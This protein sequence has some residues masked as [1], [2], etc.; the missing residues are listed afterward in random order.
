MT[1]PQPDPRETQAETP[2]TLEMPI[3]RM[4]LGYRGNKDG[5][6]YRDGWRQAA[7]AFM[8]YV[9]QAQRQRDEAIRKLEE[10]NPLETCQSCKVPMCPSQIEAGTCFKCIA[11]RFA[12]ERDEARQALS[13]RANEIAGSQAFVQLHQQT[14]TERDHWQS[15]AAQYSAER[16]SNANMAG[17]WQAKYKE[18]LNPLA[19]AV[20]RM[21]QL[22]VKQLEEVFN[23]APVE[24]PD[25]PIFIHARRRKAGIEAVRA[26][27]IQAA[28]GGES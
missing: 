19:E 10:A 22:T 25:S 7:G 1:A 16:E 20:R 6:H 21:E 13:D 24:N 11:D 8:P 2:E 27:L 17:M 9:E 12:I 23:A 5:E 3:F 14:V 15:L 4:P 28:K 26:H 18:L